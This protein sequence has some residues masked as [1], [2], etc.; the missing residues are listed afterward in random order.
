MKKTN[1]KT[2]MLEHSEAKVELY[3]KDLALYLNMLSHV[4]AVKRIF[5]FDLFCGEGIYENDSKGS[6]LVA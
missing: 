5:I 3:R 1:A 4:P 2:D 6:P